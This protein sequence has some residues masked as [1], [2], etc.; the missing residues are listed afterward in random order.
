M[1]KVIESDISSTNVVARVADEVVI[2]DVPV[3][4]DDVP[5]QVSQPSVVD[6]VVDAHVVVVNVEQV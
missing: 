3:V 4:V 5:V 1:E 2:N 6:G